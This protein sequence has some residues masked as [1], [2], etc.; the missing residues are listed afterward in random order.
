V[1]NLTAVLKE[2]ARFDGQHPEESFCC[3]FPRDW[4]IGQKVSAIEVAIELD[5]KEN[6]L[7]QR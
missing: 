2:I 6:E 5:F 7:A 1:A 4:S 3:R